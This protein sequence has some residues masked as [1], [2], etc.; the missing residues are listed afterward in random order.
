MDVAR[1]SK[2]YSGPQILYELEVEG[3]DVVLEFVKL[4]KTTVDYGFR[5]AHIALPGEIEQTEKALALI[6][7]KYCKADRPKSPF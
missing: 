3:D 4:D 5:S 1:V 6:F 7:T 2:K